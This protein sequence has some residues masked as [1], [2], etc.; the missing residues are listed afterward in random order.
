MYTS[1]KLGFRERIKIVVSFAVPG[2]ADWTEKSLDKLVLVKKPS[3]I[4]ML[5]E[6]A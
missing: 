3:I 5:S 2:S 6:F 4:I 1:G